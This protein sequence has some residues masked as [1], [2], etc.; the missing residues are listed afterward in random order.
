MLPKL[1][2]HNVIHNGNLFVNKLTAVVQNDHVQ[3]EVIPVL[4]LGIA[5]VRNSLGHHA[6]NEVNVADSTLR[7]CSGSLEKFLSPTTSLFQI[8]IIMQN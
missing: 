6:E 5:L 2:K 4:I 1:G 3:I 8:S 7:C